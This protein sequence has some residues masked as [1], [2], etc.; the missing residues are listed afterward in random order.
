MK[1]I[2][3]VFGLICALVALAPAPVRADTLADTPD[4]KVVAM[5]TTGTS[6]YNV[7]QFPTVEA[8]PGNSPIRQGTR[9]LPSGDV[10]RA[11]TSDGDQWFGIVRS[12]S[13]NCFF[14]YSSYQNMMDGKSVQK[15]CNTL[16]ADGYRGVAYDGHVFYSLFWDGSRHW[17]Q[18]YKTWRDL[19]VNKFTSQHTNQ[20]HGDIYKSIAFDA[21]SRAF[22]SLAQDGTSVWL[23]KYANYV[24]MATVTSLPNDP[25]FISNDKFAGLA[26]GPVDP[27]LDVYLVAGQSNAVGWD[28]DGAWLPAHNADAQIKFFYRI[29]NGENQSAT[30]SGTVTTLKPQQAGF[31]SSPPTNFGI[32]MGIGR[33]LWDKGRNNMAIVKVAFGGTNLYWQWSPTNNTSLYKLMLENLSIASSQWRAQGWR[34]RVVGMF[35]MQGEYDALDANMAANYKQSLTA[36]MSA[37][38]ASAQDDCLPVVIGRIRTEGWPF[39]ADVRTA[40]KNYATQTDCTDWVNT[41]DLGLVPN[42]TAHFTNDGQYTLGKRMAQSYRDLAG[43]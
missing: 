32:E 5:K 40:Q 21:T 27:V 13:K 3:S 6:T 35:W 17:W 2:A 38:R 16:V 25:S 43:W 20:R 12:G 24:D 8:I 18:T 19:A 22:W 37:V 15:I 42:D 36:F 14:Q 31:R 30:T 7:Q 4:T 28:T 26:F 29:G 11:L 1:S 34:T 39:A 33:T 9:T 41:D 10:S 23:L